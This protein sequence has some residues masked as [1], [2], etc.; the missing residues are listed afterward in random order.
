MDL[1]ALAVI[2]S[3]VTLSISILSVA[4]ASGQTHARLEGR[5]NLNEKSISVC[6]QRTEKIEKYT[7]ELYMLF[8]EDRKK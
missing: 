3:I 4:Y 1:R 8:V 6:D 2:V 5:I 7:R